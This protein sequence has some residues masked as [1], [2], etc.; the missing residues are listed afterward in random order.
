MEH[1]IRFDEDS[2]I[3]IKL[4]NGGII[5]AI[6]VVIHGLFGCCICSSQFRNFKFLML[7]FGR[8]V[9]LELPCHSVEAVLKPSRRQCDVL[10][11]TETVLTQLY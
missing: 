6:C 9:A 7:V 10:N 2:L 1:V 5:P 11:N 4:G 3:S 8:L